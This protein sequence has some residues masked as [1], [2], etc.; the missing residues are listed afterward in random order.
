[1]VTKAKPG[2]LPHC[3]MENLVTDHAFP[4]HWTPRD[5]SRIPVILAEVQARW[6]RE[7]DLRLSQLLVN[8]IR[9]QTPS[10]E[11]FYFED[12][13]LLA[14]LRSQDITDPI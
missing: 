9:P 3:T 7:P 14:L 10:P 13:K 11:I 2:Q 12:E 4:D 8:L 5:P 1:M 6:L